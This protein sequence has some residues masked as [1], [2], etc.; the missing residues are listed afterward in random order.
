MNLLALG[1]KT[2]A[3]ESDDF[4]LPVHRKVKWIPDAFEGQMCLNI[5]VNNILFI[6][7][8]ATYASTRATQTGYR[9]KNVQA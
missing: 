3:I 5:F 4:A 8:W 7:K 6:F 2:I 9:N 1:N